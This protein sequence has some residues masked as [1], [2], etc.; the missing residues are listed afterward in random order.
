MDTQ[1]YMFAKFQAKPDKK[2][3]L[4]GRLEEMVILTRKEPGCVFYHLHIDRESNDTFYFMEC[5]NDQESLDFH[6]EAPYVQAIVRDAPTLTL[7]G[8]DISFMNR[9]TL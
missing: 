1:I 2:A 7:T 6:M 4:L 8:I 9:I 5:W 3:E